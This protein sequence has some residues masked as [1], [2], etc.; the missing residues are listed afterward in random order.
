MLCVR[1]CSMYKDLGESMLWYVTAKN[2][3]DIDLESKRLLLMFSFVLFALKCS[4]RFCS[5][6]YLAYVYKKHLQYVHRQWRSQ[7]AEI[8]VDGMQRFF[9]NLSNCCNETNLK[10]CF[11]KVWFKQIHLDVCFDAFMWFVYLPILWPMKKYSSEHG[12]WRR[13]RFATTEL[14]SS[15]NNSCGIKIEIGHVKISFTLHGSSEPLL[16]QPKTLC[17]HCV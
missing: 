10:T 4:K 3:F 6:I 9:S 13:G 2:N 15:H 12:H 1:L 7:Y 14:S 8:R 17:V 16:A 11:V 5:I